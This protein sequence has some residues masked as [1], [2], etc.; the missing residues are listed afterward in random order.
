MRPDLGW[1]CLCPSAGNVRVGEG[2][3][4]GGGRGFSGRFRCCRE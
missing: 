3:E 2:R 1:F 4:G